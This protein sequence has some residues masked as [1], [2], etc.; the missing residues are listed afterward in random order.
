MSKRYFIS[1]ESPYN[2]GKYIILPVH[3]NLPITHTE[4]SYA[5]LAA[6]LLNL[7]YPN[8][9]RMCRDI[10]GAEIIGKGHLYPIAFFNGETKELKELIN[11]LNKN[12]ERIKKEFNYV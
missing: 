8:Y 12:V 7:S 9:L 2:P 5:I 3:G 4:G 11:L 1:E 6:R 10:Y